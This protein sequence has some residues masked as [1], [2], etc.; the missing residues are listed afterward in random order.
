MSERSDVVSGMGCVFC[1][2][3]NSLDASQCVQCGEALVLECLRCG[4]RNRV[5]DNRCLGCRVSLA[6]PSPSQSGVSSG[7]RRQI[8]VLFADLEGSS[9]LAESVEPEEFH[10]ILA[11]FHGACTEVIERWGGYVAQYLGDG[12]LAY[13]GFHTA[14]ENAAA[15]ATNAGLAIRE[16][17]ERLNADRSRLLRA[18]V[19]I[20]TGPVLIGEIG[21][22]ERRE[23]L[24]VGETVNIAARVQSAARPGAVVITA[25]TSDVVHSL[26]ELRPLGLHSFRGVSTPIA[27]HE[28]VSERPFYDRIDFAERE[29]LSPFVGRGAELRLLDDAWEAVKQGRGQTLLLRGEAGMGKSRHA[30][31]FRRLLAAQPHELLL[32]FCSH[33]HSETALY[34]LITSLSNW[35]RFDATSS[36]EERLAN[37]EA[38]LP[39]T[40]D[41]IV[42]PLLAALLS[43]P[44]T[45]A[46]PLPAFGPQ[47][48]RA[49]T[50]EAIREWLTRR[51]DDK[52]L[53]FVIEDLHWADPATLELV[54]MLAAEPLPR[55][56]IILTSRPTEAHNWDEGLVHTLQLGPLA[57]AEIGALLEYL[58]RRYSLQADVAAQVLQRAE[59]VPLFAEEL[60]K[61]LAALGD[62]SLANIASDPPQS[63]HEF[64]VPSTL[65]GSV[66]ARLDQLGSHK[67]VAQLA[68]TL[69]REFRLDVLQAVYRSVAGEASADVT[70]A[71][72]A[73]TQMALLSKQ[74]D[75]SY[76]FRHS[77][78]QEA[79]YRSLPRPTRAHFHQHIARVLSTDYPDSIGNEPE[80]LAQHFAKGELSREAALHYGAAGARALMRS[81]YI[82][83]AP[84][85]DRSLQCLQQLPE[86]AERDRHEVDLRAGFG[87]SL[88]LTKGFGAKEVEAIYRRGL[89]LA[90]RMQDVPLRILYGIWAFHMLRGDTAE[91]A[92]LVPAYQRICETSSNPLE[93]L[94]AHA[95][96]GSRAY[97]RGRYSEAMRD[98]ARATA[99]CDRDNPGAQCNLLLHQYNFEGL[100]YAPIFLAWCQLFAGRITSCRSGM[101]NALALAERS[102][103]PYLLCSA[104]GCIGPMMHDLSD[105]EGTASVGERLMAL[106][107]EHGFPHWIASALCLSG[108]ASARKDP[109]GPGA[110]MLQQGLDLIKTIGSYLIYPYFASYLVEVHLQAGRADQAVSCAE[111]AL[112]IGED[113]LNILFVPEIRRLRGEGLMV[114]GDVIAAENDFRVAAATT[115][116]QGAYLLALRATLSLAE[117][118]EKEGRLTEARDALRSAYQALEERSDLTEV[119][120]AEA[121]LQRHAQ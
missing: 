2:T 91:T 89:Q 84:L 101:D 18:R 60:C 14:H 100:L 92:R 43:I 87:F 69:G 85:F 54:R 15:R 29:G 48:M 56:L 28:V 7:E 46:G 8:S 70:P 112:R 30:L 102:N 99:L 38:S 109:N 36:S 20:H 25:A 58:G 5:G 115:R 105:V 23:K 37:L 26:Y 82:E 113:G 95:A 63:M 65:Q 121:W 62:P 106:A 44:P 61:S 39:N 81:A 67:S 31:E 22:G 6:V 19:G 116:A 13:F 83:A 55:V 50:L 9:A 66:S 35:L 76:A 72:A 74:N 77:L 10:R 119:N 110:A 59:G 90:E 120:R 96:L 86:S 11:D 49:R 34:P 27:L 21:S 75:G 40:S 97:Y 1:G 93:L 47:K 107:L 80:V 41:R 52:P 71:L 111:E 57:N 24:A 78:I 51:A 94:V 79:I 32:A 117:L 42:L 104:L 114:L 118:L 103:H 68:A 98:L 108:W 73:T 45:L 16:A 88:L 53:L 4:H 12:V 64:P 33:Y 3:H 17:L